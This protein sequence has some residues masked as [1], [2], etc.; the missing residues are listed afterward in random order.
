MGNNLGRQLWVKLPSPFKIKLLCN[1]MVKPRETNMLVVRFQGFGDS[2]E[3]SKHSCL[4]LGA[5]CLLKVQGAC[6]RTAQHRT[7]LQVLEHISC[8]NK[9]AGVP[10]L[11]QCPYAPKPWNRALCT[12]AAA[13]AAAPAAAAALG[14]AAEHEE[15]SDVVPGSSDSG[16][17]P[18]PSARLLGPLAWN[19]HRLKLHALLDNVWV[20]WT[21]QILACSRALRCSRRRC[22]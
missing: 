17:P 1:H 16:V 19:M 20:R 6:I 7:Y 15:G 14:A 13:A 18:P 2:V 12:V 21:R 5:G 4:M 3:S 9:L 8:A 22:L 11:R 10:S